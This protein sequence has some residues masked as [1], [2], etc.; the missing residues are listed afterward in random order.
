MRYGN[1]FASLRAGLLGVVIFGLCMATVVL[2]IHLF[3]H[4]PHLTWRGLVLIAFLPLAAVVLA[5]SPTL[6]FSIR[7][8]GGRV[9]HVMFDRYILS[10]FPLADFE[11]MRRSRGPWA[12]KLVFSDGRSIR[13]VG[14]HMEIIAALEAALEASRPAG[15]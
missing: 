6:M 11:E 8:D 1:T 10:D 7:L 3:G 9:K 15:R 13:F 2:V 14:A 12:A 5:C 4:A